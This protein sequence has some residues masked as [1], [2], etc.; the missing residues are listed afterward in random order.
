M[1][2]FRIS[3]VVV[4]LVLKGVLIQFDAQARP[5]GKFHKAILKDKRILQPDIRKT[6]LV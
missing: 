4:D 5:G 6:R 3:P 2:P 1:I